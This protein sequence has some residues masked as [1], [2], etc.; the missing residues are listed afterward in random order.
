MQR[1]LTIRAQQLGP[2]DPGPRYVQ[3]NGHRENG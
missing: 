2:E 1:A 3:K